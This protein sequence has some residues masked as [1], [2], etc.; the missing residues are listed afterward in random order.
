MTHIVVL[1]LCRQ[2]TGGVLQLPGVDAVQLLL[3]QR[4]GQHA[5]EGE[6]RGAPGIGAQLGEQGRGHRVDL[7]LEG[8][9]DGEGGH[10]DA[11]GDVAGADG[12][13]EGGED[14]HQHR[15]EHGVLAHQRHDLLGEQVQGAVLGGH[16]EQEGD[17]HQGDEHGAVKATSD[18]LGL[19]AP[20][21]TQD[22]G[23][24][25]SQKAQIDLLDKADGHHDGQY[26]QE[27]NR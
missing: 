21:R 5:G 19:Q 1:Q 26:Q 7:H 9:I 4:L 13:D 27:N 23:C 15:D 25:Q 22:K 8:E 17:A 16:A 18:G 24:A 10:Q 14:K 2:D 20:Q 12:G 11:G 6:G 3:R